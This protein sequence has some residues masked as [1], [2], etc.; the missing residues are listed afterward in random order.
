MFTG[1]YKEVI[2]MS[3]INGTSFNSSSV[4][5]RLF[6]KKDD[7]NTKTSGKKTENTSATKDSKK[8][9]LVDKFDRSDKVKQSCIGNV[10]LSD[11]AKS[12]LEE[13]KEKYQNMDFFVAKYNSDE[14]ASDIMARGTKEYGV[15]I[16]PETLEKMA[17][18]EEVKNQYLAV[19]DGAT[20]K[21]E[22]MK[23]QLEDSG[24]EVER[25]GMVINGDGTVDYFAKLRENTE[26]QAKDQA[27]KIEECRAEKIKARKEE[28]KERLE[29]KKEKTVTV[30]ASSIEELVKKV[31]EIDWTT[32]QE[33]K[34]EEAPEVGGKFDFSV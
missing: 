26:K 5:D 29:K 1:W 33:T 13:L 28:E 22:E 19:I 11:K 3:G 2:D 14:E 20:D 30:R 27:E 7:K 12:L 10:E 6:N 16:D 8:P 32:I 15:L 23:T 24:S 25:L 4:M 21:F 31:K 17:E 18:D 9:V 34:K